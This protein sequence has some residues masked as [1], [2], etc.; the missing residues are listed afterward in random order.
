MVNTNQKNIFQHRPYKKTAERH[1][2]SYLQSNHLEALTEWLVEWNSEL[3]IWICF[4]LSRKTQNMGLWFYCSQRV[5]KIYFMTFLYLDFEYTWWRL[6]QKP[7]ARTKLDIY[8]FITSKYLIKC[9]CRGIYLLIV[10][11]IHG[12]WSRYFVFKLTCLCSPMESWDRRHRMIVGFTT[13]CAIG[14]YHH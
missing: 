1:Q 10:L 6:L 7:I 5:K 9:V 14:A 4:N 13:T 11:K 2:I 12:D 3:Y 8:V